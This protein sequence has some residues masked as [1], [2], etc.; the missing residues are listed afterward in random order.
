M[1]QDTYSRSAATTTAVTVV[2]SRRAL[3]TA[4]V[5]R[6]GG[7]R[8]E[9]GMVAMSAGVPS[10]DHA[11]GL[12]VKLDLVEP[13]AQA[14]GLAGDAAGDAL[15]L[16]AGADVGCAAAANP[17]LDVVGGEGFGGLCRRHVDTVPRVDTGV[18][19]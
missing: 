8:S 17:G 11:A 6:S 7:M 15:G 4:A 3:S 18:K 16:V 14:F 12:L 2:P 5:Q 13:D 1:S 9:R 10:D 19:R